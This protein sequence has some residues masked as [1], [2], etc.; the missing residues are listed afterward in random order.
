MRRFLILVVIA[1]LTLIAGKSQVRHM[2]SRYLSVP[3]GT[4]SGETGPHEF[5]E[6]SA[7]GVNY[8]SWQATDAMAATT[9]YTLPP[10]FPSSSGDVLSSTT[11]GVTTWIAPPGGVPSG[12]AGGSLAGTYPNPTLAASQSDDLVWHGDHV[13]NGIALISDPAAGTGIWGAAGLKYRSST[14]GEGDGQTNHVH[15]R[16]EETT[17]VG[18]VY[19]FTTS[20]AK[21]AFGT[22]S[23]EVTLPTAGTWLILA[24]LTIDYATATTTNQT[25]TVK[26]RN[27]T[28]GADLG[29]SQFAMGLGTYTAITEM[30]HSGEWSGITAV[31]GGSK[32]VQIFGQ[33]SGA[34]GGGTIVAASGYMR[35]IRLF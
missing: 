27:V 9:L 34:I 19:T 10:A 23:P 25:V 22:T 6:L 30:F 7:N 16:F 11:A 32:S 26:I 24:R 29:G 12:A 1:G 35:A 28:D 18:T 14:A 31:S 17:A 20:M 2:A 13:L 3:F 8:F 4:S 21:V 33:L 5:Y 15:N